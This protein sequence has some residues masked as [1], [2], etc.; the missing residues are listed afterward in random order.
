[1]L[2]FQV[3]RDITGKTLPPDAAMW[4]NWYTRAR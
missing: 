2:G 4:R 1:M 3:L